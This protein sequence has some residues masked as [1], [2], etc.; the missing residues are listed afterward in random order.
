MAAV[1]FTYF[2]ACW[3]YYLGISIVAATAAA[4]AKFQQGKFQLTQTKVQ[5]TTEQIHAKKVKI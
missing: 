4:L 2:V 5:L 3:K 1:D